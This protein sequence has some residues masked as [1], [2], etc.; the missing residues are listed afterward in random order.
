MTLADPFGFYQAGMEMFSAYMK[1]CSDFND[2]LAT[3][4]QNAVMMSNICNSRVSNV[5]QK[6]AESASEQLKK[7]Q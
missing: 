4:Y 7:Y 2:A 6:H 3:N 5:I 1:F